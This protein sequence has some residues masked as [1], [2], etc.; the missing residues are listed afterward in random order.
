M[1]DG[2]EIHTGLRQ[3]T[4]HRRLGLFLM[5][6]L[7]A[8][9]VGLF[10]LAAEWKHSLAIQ[11]ISV[12]GLQSVPL[13][14]IVGLA[15]IRLHMELYAF[16]LLDVQ[17]RMMLKPF[18]KT[19]RVH[20]ELPGTIAIDI[21]EREPIASI[22]TGQLYLVDADGVV[23]PYVGLQKRF[24]VPVIV[25]IE[26]LRTE[27]VGVP[28]M[29]KE[30]FKAI[31]VLKSAMALDTVVYRMISEIDMKRGGDIVLYSAD[32]GVPVI[33]GRERIPE[34]LLMFETFWSKYVG[35]NEA[36]K[37]I[38]VDLRFEDQIVVKWNERQES[39]PK[40]LSL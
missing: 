8:G 6:S 29:N 1:S 39:Q 27:R 9:M 18:I 30:L 26:G 3:T 35:A 12:S 40:A 15:N 19:A 31:Q 34:K 13:G 37:L 4:G 16:D 14:E 36:E 21:V 32:S 25:G 20:R 22:N 5:I 33:L 7:F 28:L 38:Y 24:D 17:R 11:N 10:V 2:Y 23:L